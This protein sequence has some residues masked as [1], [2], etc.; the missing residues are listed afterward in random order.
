MAKK[1]LISQYTFDASTRTVVID[2]NI[3]PE[4]LLL[5]TNVTT[6]TIIYNFATNGFGYTSRTFDATTLKTTFVLEQNTT[7]M[8][9]TDALQIF[10]E[11]STT[12]FEPD[13]TYT[14]PVSKIRVSN[15]ENLIDTDFEY[16]LQSTK[17]ETLELTNNIP[18]FF[19][20]D[21]DEE[22]DVSAI[23][24]SAGSDVVQVT[25][26]F[27]HGL[28]RG[29]PIIMQSTGNVAADGGFIVT[30]VGSSTTF[31]FKAKTTFTTTQ[32][33][34]ETY[35]QL[36]TAK[37]YTG[38]EFKL[39]QIG[40]ISTDGAASS[41]LTVNT[42]FPTSFT[43]GSSMALSNS[44][45][46]STVD[47]NTDNVVVDN[48][49]VTDISYTS[50]TPT[51]EDDKFRLGG[52]DPFRYTLEPLQ[53][54]GNAHYFVEGTTTVDTTN[55]TITFPSAHGFPAP[56]CMVTYHFEPNTNT[57]IGGLQ[58]MR[59]YFC[60]RIDDTTIAL[61]YSTSTSTQYRINLSGNGTSGG[62]LKSCFSQASWIYYYYGYGWYRYQFYVFVNNMVKD[63][64][65]RT[66]FGYSASGAN[67]GFLTYLNAS[68]GNS[69]TQAYGINDVT[70]P[71]NMTAPDN[72]YDYYAR[73]YSSQYSWATR[74][75]R[76]PNSGL[77]GG[78]SVADSSDGA[79]ND[80]E[81]DAA[82]S[83]LWVPNHGLSN[84]DIVTV[85]AT[86]GTLPSGLNTGSNYI[87]KVINSNR[88]AFIIPGS[89][90]V[91]FGDVG[92]ANLVYRIQCTKPKTD[93]N[94]ITISGNTLQDTSAIK[95]DKNSGT[96]IGGLTDLQ[97]YYVA[98]KVGDAFKLSTT[99]NP[100]S[101][102]H[103]ISN[104]AQV[105]N[106][107]YPNP[108]YLRL[109]GNPFAT[110][111]AVQY[112]ANDPLPGLI[113]GGIYF[114]R[115]QGAGPFY[116]LHNSKADAL[117]S[118]NAVNIVQY[119]TGSATLTKI[120][121][122]DITT[123]P[124]NETQ[125]LEADYIGAADGLYSVAST[126]ADQLSFTFS[127]GQ[128][129]EARS[130]ITTAQQSFVAE[131]DA[132]RITDHGFITGDSVTYTTSGT[133]NITGL[134]SSTTYYIVRKNKDF[135]QF[136][137]TQADATAIP[138]V[139]ISLSETGASASELTGTITLQPTT[140]VGSYNG[141]GSVSYNA[142]ALTLT[143]NDTNFLSYFSKGDSFFI[144][145]A[146]TTATTVIT[147][148]DTSADTFE[149]A[150]HTI[151]TGDM[152]TFSG[153]TIPTGFDA[154]KIYFAYTVDV[155]NFSVH[156]T[157]TDAVANSNKIATTDAGSSASVNRIT[158]TGDII[159]R[160]IDYVNSDTQIT[161]TSALPATAQA[162]AKYLQNTSLLLRP[163]G[164]ALHRPYDGGVELIPSTNP[165]STMIRQTRKYFRYQSGKGIQVSFAVNFSPTSQIDS[166]T[167][168]G[169][170][171]TIVTR[172]PHRLSTDLTIR[173]SGSTNTSN[174]TIGT[175]N[176]DITVVT[177]DSGNKYYI[178]GQLLTTYELKEG[179]TYRF[180]QDNSSNNGHPLR[181]ST[182]ADGTH[183]GGVEYTTGVTTNGSP[184][185]SGAYTE[186]V[187]AIGAPTLY[188]YCTQHSGMGFEVTTVTDSANNKANLWNGDL[189]VLSVVDNFTFTVEL[190][191]TPSDASATGIV[192]YYVTQWEN[193][194][195]KC[196]LF[197]DQNGLYFE[198]NGKD[199]S[200]CRRSSIRQIS[201]YANVQ[202]RSGA[203]IGTNSKF[204]TQLNQGS[205][206]VI[207]GQS[208]KVTKISSDTLMYVTPSYRGVTAEKV[209]ITVTEDTK[210][211]QAQ[212][213][214][215]PSDGTGPSGFVFDKYK[216]QMAYIDYS[217]YGAGKVR[218][219]FK[220]QNGNVKYVHSFVHGNVF[221]EAYMRSGNVPARYEI[222]NVG[223]PSYV[224][225][226]AH[227]GTSVIMDGR[228]DSDKAYVFSA[229]SKQLTLT[230]VSQQTTN[231][232]VDFTGIYWG[233]T[234]GRYR[235]LGYALELQAPSSVLNTITAGLEVSGADLQAGTR[236]ANPLSTQFSPYQPYQPSRFSRETQFYSN[237]G[238]YRDLLIIDKAPT[239]T[240]SGFTSYTLGAASGG[241]IAVNKDLPVISIR[242]AP[243]VDTSAPGFLGER[244][245]VNRMQL[246][247]NSVNI[248]S[249]HACTI[250][251]I[252]NGELSSNAWERVTTPSLSQLITHTNADTILGGASVFN[253]EAQGGT[254][255]T[256]RT[257]VL[258][259]TA[260]GDIAT[261]GNSIL[262]GDNVFPDGP[263]VLTVVATLSEDP[264]TVTGSN[265]FVVSGRISWSE[266]Q[267]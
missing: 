116:Y 172:F 255:T 177:T 99:Q 196:G 13:E 161:F 206:V 105:A 233:Y 71:Y 28:Q 246:I 11:T 243:S 16:G 30:S 78:Y 112:T 188:T 143:G 57:G 55:N 17:W 110:G 39:N 133:T 182:T 171:G 239:G 155:D 33:I 26:V 45:A 259:T 118:S 70:T 109:N 15:P 44:F 119:A 148:T 221:T 180:R 32:N 136:A 100:Y 142:D 89:S 175:A 192:E 176:I 238:A 120:N 230:G 215:D 113:N 72:N 198:F 25:T 18:T 67:R 153:T 248:I 190:S 60:H 249:T 203:V 183:G 260:L 85:S 92:S 75:F 193:S 211:E 186:I 156:Y 205:M 141:T 7:S 232:R 222:E 80:I 240:S 195:L 121:I 174:D 201:G 123:A 128:K 4:R 185:T 264:A 35:T 106:L 2:D 14:D 49:D 77:N 47:F 158:S 244:E 208:Y 132:L 218:F 58:N 131:L 241:E 220:D 162:E 127:A 229:P 54:T 189:Q 173:T 122:I 43:N 200:C 157:R 261:L 257:P 20:R 144:N 181:F 267:A 251:L 149:A 151:V 34:K 81:A 150:G 56:Y 31:S 234:N 52:V 1:L 231:A 154:T 22:V 213:S 5:I 256:A 50:A 73:A 94:T 187:V 160:T 104:Q 167:R 42:V 19:S 6:N 51:G 137:S 98:F 258:T 82:S 130:K 204:L 68:T 224:P 93:A 152:I 245:I 37:I 87:A 228:F 86:T 242:L 129:I 97:T 216:I 124:T 63:N 210:I 139:I 90:E 253:F 126:A 165:D 134:T 3:L 95:Y 159:E 138:P 197:D 237:T 169:T 263:D 83:S 38:T 9:D 91:S 12:A 79:W 88:L 212:W 227:W 254:G 40:G 178:E 117:S 170:T 103:T 96:L 111:D 214:I 23:Q 145:Q 209:V 62:I 107:V 41:T 53:G 225:A 61:S 29:S 48:V 102:V 164:F 140:I 146:G 59:S 168:S 135:I 219:G 115:L 217:W 191:G 66:A 108:G 84:G 199:L 46:K 36:F 262:G 147:T 64:D 65:V 74:L 247:L 21:G 27:D 114:A 207:K 226:L 166:F 194:L 125:K 236:A 235:N 252:L 76:S 24:V 266:S 8:A 184:G 163:D 265:P 179:R 10:I 101:T 69:F 223:A 250:Q 202:F